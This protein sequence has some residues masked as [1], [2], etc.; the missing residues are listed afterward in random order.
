MGPA[1]PCKNLVF[2]LSVSSSRQRVSGPTSDVV[3]PILKDT[4]AAVLRSVCRGR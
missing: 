2:A 4:Q 3:R 1:G